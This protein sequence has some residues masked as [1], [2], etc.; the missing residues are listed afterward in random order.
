[1]F[2]FLD[3]PRSGSVLG[4][5]HRPDLDGYWTLCNKVLVR[6]EFSE[7]YTVNLRSPTPKGKLGSPWSSLGGSLP[8]VMLKK[9]W[10]LSLKIEFAYTIERLGL[11]ISGDVSIFLPPYRL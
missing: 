9:L 2:N 11:N 7:S 1:M 8:P 3:R 4:I 6:R 10:L 5:C